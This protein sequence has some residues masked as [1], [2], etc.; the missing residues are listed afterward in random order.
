ML[1]KTFA[2]LLSIIIFVPILIVLIK[3]R[4]RLE[5]IIYYTFVQLMTTI[6]ISESLFPMI[7]Q[8]A[9]I[10]DDVYSKKR[11]TFEFFREIKI[12]LSL[13]LTKAQIYR[14]LENHIITIVLPL[15]LMG[16]LVGLVIRI[17]VKG[18]KKFMMMC[19]LIVIVIQMVKLFT[20][21]VVGAKYIQVTPEDGVYIFLGC[22]CGAGVLCIIQKLIYN[23]DYKS[24]FFSALKNILLG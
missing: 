5:T 18:R 6:V 9:I 13:E 2:Y 15:I 19:M 17:Q 1:D 20:C 16:I 10:E 21:M 8:K 12:I 3:K 11:Q 23:I 4:K 7:V 14:L 24:R 22:L